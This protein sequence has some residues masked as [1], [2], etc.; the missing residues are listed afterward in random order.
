MTF[1]SFAKCQTSMMSA[2]QCPKCHAWIKNSGHYYRHFK[3]CGTVAHRVTCPYCPVTFA[4]NDLCKRHIKN[5]HSK[6][7]KRKAE[8]G[9]SRLH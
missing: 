2:R 5:I 9:K 3:R 8:D 1:V 6:G 7:A 4:R